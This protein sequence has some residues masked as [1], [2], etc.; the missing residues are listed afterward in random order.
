MLK[1][2]MNFILIIL[3]YVIQMAVN[4]DLKEIILEIKFKYNKR[5]SDIADDLGI[6]TTYLS[7]MINGRVRTTDNIINKIHELYSG[8]ANNNSNSIQSE[9]SK[10][11][12]NDKLSFGSV[13]H[14][15]NIGRPFYNIDW[16]LGLEKND[17]EEYR[18]PEFNIDF[19]PANKEGIEWYR[20]KGQSM[21][22]E[23]DSGDYIALER[24]IDFSWFPLGRIYGVISSNG[25]RTIKRITSGN[26]P[27]EF[28]LISSNPDKSKFPDQP[29]KKEM[30]IGLY[31]LKFV[32]K[33][34]DE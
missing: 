26:N 34:L 32:I 27:D 3:K 18:Y 7:D 2:N 4:Q 33:D 12:I 14:N 13:S 10:E 1:I 20:A 17:F 11:D 24:V 30:I 29:I 31:S 21:L 16:T 5:Q 19:Q 6:K 22:G 28:L 9:S 25:F 8:I 15:Q 23:I